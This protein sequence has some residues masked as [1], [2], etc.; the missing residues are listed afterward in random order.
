MIP[1]GISDKLGNE[2]EAL[3]AATQLIDIY[4]GLSVSLK[5]EPIEVGG[6]EFELRFKNHTEW[7]QSKQKSTSGRWTIGELS[8][9]DVLG[10]FKK[11]LTTDEA[12]RCVFITDNDAAALG[13]LAKKAQL[14]ESERDFKKTLSDEN[15][16][17]FSALKVSWGTD[18][19]NTYELL[20]RIFVETVSANSVK[21][22]L[23]RLVDAHFLNDREDAVFAPFSW[24]INPFPKI[25]NDHG[26]PSK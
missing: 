9:R 1:G 14:V 2:Y 23:V 19:F 10:Q 25:L 24:A 11:R 16:G 15:N 17:D 6:F 12:A 22:N 3:W 18:D 8:R 26:L 4:R 21:R 13:A 7:H 5:Y 20:K